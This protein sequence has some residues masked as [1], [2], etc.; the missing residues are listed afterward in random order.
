MPKV[1]E[2]LFCDAVRALSETIGDRDKTIEKLRERLSEQL[3]INRRL[4]AEKAEAWGA[5]A[6]RAG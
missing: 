4:L 3:C 6:R 2:E 1:S 5:S